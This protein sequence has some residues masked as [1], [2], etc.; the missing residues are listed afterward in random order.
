MME[1]F[2]TVDVDYLA[3]AFNREKLRRLDQ[4]HTP[5]RP[6]VLEPLKQVGYRRAEPLNWTEDASAPR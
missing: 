3:F 2:D 5:V 6:V 1:L 4:Q